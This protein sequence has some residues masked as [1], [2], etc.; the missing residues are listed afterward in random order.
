MK[1]CAILITVAMMFAL[2]GCQL[3]SEQESASG[4]Q[5]VGVYITTEYLDLMDMDAYLNDHLNEVANGGNIV[6]E[7]GDARAYQERVY[8]V[9]VSEDPQHPD[10]RFPGIKGVPVY[11]V[12]VPE[13]DGDGYCWTPGRAPEV[14]QYNAY[15]AKDGMDDVVIT[16]ELYVSADEAHHEFYANPMYRTAEG[17]VY[18]VGSTGI[19]GDMGEAGT[20]M[21]Q[22]VEETNTMTINGETTQQRC[23]VKVTI[24]SVYPVEKT[25]L[26]QMDGNNRVIASQEF[27]PGQVP[28]EFTPKENTAYLVVETHRQSKSGDQTVDRELFD[29]EDTSFTTYQEGEDGFF[30]RIDTVIHWPD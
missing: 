11:S 12:P 27:L 10:Y 17:E 1:K 21:S 24:T 6:V 9:D 25:V 23:E 18:L 13:P 15:T 22:T 2:S 19:S 16:A 20:S 14:W 7:E 3:A 29:R 28:A 26:I 8:A 4:D 5:L 30:C